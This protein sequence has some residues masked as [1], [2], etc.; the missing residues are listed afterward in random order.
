MLDGVSAENIYIEQYVAYN[1]SSAPII[2]A[3]GY[4]V[5]CCDICGHRRR[6]S[7][8]VS[9]LRSGPAFDGRTVCFRGCPDTRASTRRALENLGEDVG[10]RPVHYSRYRRSQ[11]R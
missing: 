6:L 2:S 1:F 7:P 11:T 5:C 10:H 4:C 8:G 9:R 3:K